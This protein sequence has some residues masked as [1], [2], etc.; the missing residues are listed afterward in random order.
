MLYLTSDQHFFHE[1]IIEACKRPYVNAQKM[2]NE[3]VY[4][5]NSI[6]TNQDEVIMLGDLTMRASDQI[7][8][9]ESIIQKLNG[10]KY[11]VFGNHDKF[12]P[13]DYLEMGFL[14]ASTSMKIKACGIDV[15]CVHD[16]VVACLDPNQIFLCG[17]VHNWWKKCKNAIN[18]GVDV[19]NFFPVSEHQIK[20]L[21][22]QDPVI[23]N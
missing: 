13:F 12:K 20:E 14:C 10:K 3:I 8:S 23:Q 4:K 19:W 6:V 11:F 7:R 17:H 2:N 9:I 18:V 5:Y 16:P 1:S 15:I 22:D 21:I